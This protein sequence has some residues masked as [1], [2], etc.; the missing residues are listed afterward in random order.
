MSE[1]KYSFAPSKEGNNFRIATFSPEKEV[2][3]WVDGQIKSMK[4]TNEGFWETEI[5]LEFTSSLYGFMVNG[6]GPYPDPGGRFMP[7]GIGGLS[8]LIGMDS[9][10]WINNNWTG[11]PVEKYIIEEVHVGTYTEPGTYS[12]ME[13]RLEHLSNLGVTA[14]EIMPV[15]Q[16]YGSRNWGYDGVYLYS[17]HFGYGTPDQLKHLVDAIHGRGMCAV[18]DVVYNHSG[19]LGNYL[20][21]YAQYHNTGYSTPWGNCFNLD[22]PG[23]DGIREYILQ[24]AIFWLSEFRFDALRLDAVH[25]IV[26]HSPL[27]ILKELKFPR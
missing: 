22:G 14:V 12:G 7:D 27:H 5:S 26:D 13:Q 20:D 9:Y 24:N 8:Q 10:G 4:K 1:P 16:F 18:L 19:P 11:L 2:S 23:S 15:A 6:E 21:K 3:L 17:P 25:G